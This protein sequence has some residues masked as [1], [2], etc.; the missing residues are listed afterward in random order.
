MNFL[1]HL[2]LSGNSE[3]VIMGNFVAD[4]VKGKLTS[5]RLEMWSEG[6]GKGLLLHRMIDSYTDNNVEL[7]K[8]KRMMSPD[9]GKWSGV[10]ADIYF[11]YFLANHFES[12]YPI[13]LDTFV[14]QMHK[15]V[16]DNKV[17]VPAPMLTLAEAMIKQEWLKSYKSIDGIGRTFYNLSMRNELRRGL[18]GAEYNLIEN[19]HKYE[20][21]FFEFYPGLKKI[22]ADFLNN[23]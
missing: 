8:M 20:A 4:F 16:L 7:K 9:F 3:T 11:D 18:K 5:E 1:A 21:Y 6:F 12:Y 15:V 17:L 23:N 22:C 19:K 13:K 14:D 2:A 10:V